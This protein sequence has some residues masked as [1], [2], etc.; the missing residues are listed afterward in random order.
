[1]NQGRMRVSV[2]A[3]KI[4]ARDIRSDFLRAMQRAEAGDL[5]PECRLYYAD[6]E[7][8]AQRLPEDLRR[9]VED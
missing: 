3:G 2:R 9:A 8:M 5:T 4:P 6:T 7:T 1:M